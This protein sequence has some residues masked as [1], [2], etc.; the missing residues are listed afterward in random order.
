MKSKILTNL[1]E[2]TKTGRT[3]KNEDTNA[4]DESLI[5]D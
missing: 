4:K 1:V 5:W 2:Y 3:A